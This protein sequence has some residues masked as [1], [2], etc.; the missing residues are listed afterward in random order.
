MW[1]STFSNVNP[2]ILYS[3][4]RGIS[5]CWFEIQ[6]KKFQ[7]TYSGFNV[8]DKMDGYESEFEFYFEFQL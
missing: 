4:S 6:I 1:K 2:N 8:T 5:G 7:I 3:F